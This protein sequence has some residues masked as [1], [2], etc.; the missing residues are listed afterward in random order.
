MV[1]W[2]KASIIGIGIGLLPALPWYLIGDI[3]QWVNFILTPGILVAFPFGG[4]HDMKFAVVQI[5]TC[6]F[7]SALV[8]LVLRRHRKSRSLLKNSP[9]HR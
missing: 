8:Y 3:Q 1:M 6:V 7:Y 4:P 9:L 2:I 5:A